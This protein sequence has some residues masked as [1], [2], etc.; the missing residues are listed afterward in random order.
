MHGR[1]PAEDA[2]SAHPKTLSPLAPAP[3]RWTPAPR[4]RVGELLASSWVLLTPLLGMTTWAAFLYIGIRGHR[5]R[6]L[7]WAAFYAAGFAAGLVVKALS[8][9]DDSTAGGFYISVAVGGL[10]HALAI[11][12]EALARM[13]GQL[14]PNDPQLVRRQEKEARER[15]ELRARM[16]RLAEDDPETARE[17]GLG[18]PGNDPWASACST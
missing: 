13:D 1:D 11:R 15:R 12:R 10:V 6:W 2:A 17:M 7:L 14:A 3:H 18:L 9:E 16:R 4:S 5:R 8:G